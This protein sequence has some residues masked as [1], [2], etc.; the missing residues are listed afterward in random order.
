MPLEDRWR[1]LRQTG[2]AT[3][4]DAS[5]EEPTDR[6]VA[7]LDDMSDDDRLGHCSFET[8]KFDWLPT[9]MTKIRTANT[10]TTSATVSHPRDQPFT[11]APVMFDAV[12]L[13]GIFGFLILFAL[14]AH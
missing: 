9:Y 7:W 3:R 12:L 8:S 1:G 5:L 11:L 2:A 13:I 4:C 6:A 14:S 10:A